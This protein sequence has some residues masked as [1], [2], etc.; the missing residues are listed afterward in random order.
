MNTN[1]YLIFLAFAIISFADLLMIKHVI[2]GRIGLPSHI[3]NNW[4]MFNMFI[5]V[6]LLWLMTNNMLRPVCFGLASF[7]VVGAFTN[8]WYN[9][10]VYLIEYRLKQHGDFDNTMLSVIVMTI[11]IIVLIA[12]TI[13][14]VLKLIFRWGAL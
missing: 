11:E 5:A 9:D 7:L 10:F 3:W 14:C 6:I 13:N 8:V 1:L 4:F 12:F 2:G